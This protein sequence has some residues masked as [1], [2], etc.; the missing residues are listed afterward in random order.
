[1]YML[2]KFVSNWIQIWFFFFYF[3]F[4]KILNFAVN[5]SHKSQFLMEENSFKDKVQIFFLSSSNVDSDKNS[6]LTLR[7][8][9]AIPQ[10]KLDTYFFFI[11]QCAAIQSLYQS[12]TD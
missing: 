10:W 12:K 3:L 5:C 9:S 8:I 4:D 6:M 2:I 11:I 1:M 7:I